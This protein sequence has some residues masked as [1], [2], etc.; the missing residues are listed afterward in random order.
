MSNTFVHSI[1]KPELPPFEMPA[2]FRTDVSYFMTPSGE[3]G[4]PQLQP[5]EFWIRLE[6]AKRWLDE[7]VVPVVSP[8]S[9]EVKS[10]IELTED[11]EAW[12][13]WMVSNSI[14]H[15]RLE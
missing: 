7:F 1:E 2:R 11:Q 8:L 12:L 10:E 6:N 15:I 13:E 4:A 9:A 3:D 5:G 14:Q